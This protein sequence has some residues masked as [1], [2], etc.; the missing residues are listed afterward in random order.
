MDI[1][2]VSEVVEENDSVSP[3]FTTDCL[4]KERYNNDNNS[5]NIPHN[6]SSTSLSAKNINRPKKGQGRTARSPFASKSRSSPAGT[7]L[8]ANHVMSLSECVNSEL[9]VSHV[10]D[11]EDV[12]ED[13]CLLQGTRLE[14]YQPSPYTVTFQRTPNIWE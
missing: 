1:S 12:D 13:D 3:E 6:K 4:V 10:E 7:L 2:D 14:R 9:I 11:E 5:Q 8:A